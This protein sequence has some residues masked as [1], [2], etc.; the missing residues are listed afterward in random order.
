MKIKYSLL[1]LFATMLLV[2]CAHVE[3][4]DGRLARLLSIPKFIKRNVIMTSGIAF[5]TA[6]SI[7]LDPISGEQINPCGTNDDVFITQKFLRAIGRHI[8]AIPDS[9]DKGAKPCTKTQIVDANVTLVAAIK[10]SEKPI[11]GT[12]RV[13]GKE[14]P[15]RF[16]VTVT[17]LHEG[18]H[19]TTTYSEG[20]QRTNC[21]DNQTK[22]DALNSLGLDC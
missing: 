15:A 10:S 3:H 21:I 22:C 4:P 14:K 20:V 6:K 1:I 19:C 2:S 17:A 18:S 9:A 8:H 5:N 16:V 11:L 7:T 13:N 12:V